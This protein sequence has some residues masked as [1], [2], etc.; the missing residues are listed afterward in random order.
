MYAIVDRRKGNPERG[1]E[2]FQRAQSEFFPG[3][4]KAA[5]FTGFYLVNDEI[6]GLDSAIFVWESKEH[7][8]AFE[9]AYSDWMH[10]MDERGHIAQSEDR[11]ETF[12]LEPQR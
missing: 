5:G 3:L 10:T 6:N 7:A 12:A 11:G 4:Q 1:E 9:R 2:T 8:D